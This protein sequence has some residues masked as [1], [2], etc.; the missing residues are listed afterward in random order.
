MAAMLRHFQRTRLRKVENLTRNR[1]A[2][3]K[4]SRQRCP[5]APANRRNVIPDTIRARRPAQRLALV[6]RLTARLAARL[7]PQALCATLTRGL[8]QPVARR[9]LAAVAAVQTKTTLQYPYPLPKPRVL[10]LKTRDLLSRS[11]GPGHPQRVK[12]LG[13]THPKVDSFSNRRV[14]PSADRTSWAVTMNLECTRQA[15]V[16][17]R[18]RRKANNALTNAFNDRH[19]SVL[20]LEPPIV[21]RVTVARFRGSLPWPMAL[22]DE[23]SGFSA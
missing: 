16:A 19:H 20:Y 3:K 17:R 15:I 12:R 6:A 8:L 2:H 10:Q 9:R 21:A 23:R 18:R 1:R 5:A 4:R 13:T 22:N 14:N 7:A 11:L